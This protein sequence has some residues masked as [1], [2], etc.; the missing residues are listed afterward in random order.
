MFHWLGK[1]TD[2]EPDLAHIAVKASSVEGV[3]S[4]EFPS[5]SNKS[6]KPNRAK[7]S[8][9]KGVG[10]LFSACPRVKNFVAVVENLT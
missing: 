10:H 9:S 4:I 5:S 2:L 6:S 7:R 1:K 3:V 8:N